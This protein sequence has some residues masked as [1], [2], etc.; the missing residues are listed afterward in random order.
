MR[1]RRMGQKYRGGGYGRAPPRNIVEYIMETGPRPGPI[2]GLAPKQQKQAGGGIC[3]IEKTHRCQ[4]G[5]ERFRGARGNAADTVILREKGKRADNLG[6][7]SDPEYARRLWGGRR[8]ELLSKKVCSAM[9][10][11]GLTGQ[12]PASDKNHQVNT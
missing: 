9:C 1:A 4:N 7:D 8:A 2:R 10:R 11:S 5:G 6:R 12:N 3:S